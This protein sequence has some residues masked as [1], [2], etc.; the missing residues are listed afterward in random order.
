MCLK[1]FFTER[2]IPVQLSDCRRHS[3][4]D[5]VF[6]HTVFPLQLEYMNGKHFFINQTDDVKHF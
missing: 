2:M 6:V 5:E 3:A 1:P 4:A